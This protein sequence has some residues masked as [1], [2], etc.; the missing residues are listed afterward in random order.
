MM[1]PCDNNFH[2]SY[3]KLEID[4]SPDKFIDQVMGIDGE[5]VKDNNWSSNELYKWEFNRTSK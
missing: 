4:F 5:F 1:K 2:E 3:E